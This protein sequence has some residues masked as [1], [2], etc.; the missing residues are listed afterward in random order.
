MGINYDD[1]WEKVKEG[2]VKAFENLFKT[3][4]SALCLYTLHFTKDIFIAQEIVQDLFL[5]LW[6]G[7]EKI[8]IK[9]SFKSYLYQSAHNKAINYIIQQKTRKQ[10]VNK[11]FPDEVWLSLQEKNKIDANFIEQLEADETEII[12]NNAINT[13]PEQCNKVFTLSRFEGKSIE[14][15]ADLLKITTHTVRSHI[16]KALEIIRGSLEKKA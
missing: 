5:S 6:Q 10:T 13:L 4:N 11:L 1:C 12:V 15:I 7:K 16:Y 8:N 3:S 14:E 2:D 9:G